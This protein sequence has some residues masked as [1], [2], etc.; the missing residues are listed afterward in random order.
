M[1]IT[2]TVFRLLA[3]FLL[4]DYPPPKPP[5]TDVI[6]TTGIILYNEDGCIARGFDF[7]TTQFLG[8]IKLAIDTNNDGHLPGVVG[9][10]EPDLLARIN[11]WDSPISNG[12]FRAH[13]HDIR[14]DTFK[15]WM[16]IVNGMSERINAGYSIH[17]DR[18]N[19]TRI[20]FL[21]SYLVVDDLPDQ[22][23][24]FHLPI[25][26]FVP[27]CEN[28]YFVAKYIKCVLSH[29]IINNYFIFRNYIYRRPTADEIYN[30]IKVWYSL[31]NLELTKKL[32]LFGRPGPEVALRIIDPSFGY[33]SM[34]QGHSW[35]AF[36]L[37]IKKTM[38]Y[39]I[40]YAG[41]KSERFD[42][43]NDQGIRLLIEEGGDDIV[44]ALIEGSTAAIIYC[45]KNK[46]DIEIYRKFHDL[47]NTT[48][49]L[50]ANNTSLNSACRIL[51]LSST[52]KFHKLKDLPLWIN[53]AIEIAFEG[54]ATFFDIRFKRLGDKF[55]IL[56]QMG[57]SGTKEL[58]K[59]A[60]DNYLT[61]RKDESCLTISQI[62]NNIIIPLIES[63]HN[64]TCSHM[65][66]IYKSK[67]K[68]DRKE[69]KSKLE[70]EYS[71]VT[72]KIL[73]KVTGIP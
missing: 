31:P 44:D 21:I 24:E 7:Q 23:G 64:E 59:L 5:G 49:W 39:Y 30:F 51:Q 10:W 47:E 43:D 27:H 35:S 60:I 25:S 20:N 56:H 1:T 28:C 19:A 45:V 48:F 41:Y 73:S 3:E 54:L 46:F 9:Y 15:G 55:K 18:E 36:K 71:N 63:L 37:M 42:I 11:N 16:S 38:P 69:L 70:D 58:V 68:K 40:L 2:H 14:M 32:E 22:S 6:A 26:E 12:Q 57:L 65:D 13:L 33:S 17:G 29:E 4:S 50:D 52:A 72:Q 66:I 67:P 8:R 53:I 34:G 61:N 62:V